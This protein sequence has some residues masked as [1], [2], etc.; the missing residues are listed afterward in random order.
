MMTRPLHIE[1]LFSDPLRSLAFTRLLD[2]LKRAVAFALLWIGGRQ[3]YPAVALFHSIS[4]TER[5]PAP[6]AQEY[7]KPSL[8]TDCAT[9]RF[10]VLRILGNLARRFFDGNVVGL[11]DDV[12]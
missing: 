8:R 4:R 1:N 7:G 10:S 11:Q 5:Q 3:H 9:G 12:S 6:S 2:G